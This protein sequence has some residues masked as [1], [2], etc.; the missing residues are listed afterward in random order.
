MFYDYHK[1][2][3]SLAVIAMQMIAKNANLQLVEFII[4]RRL[5]LL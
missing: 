4:T 2:L 5:V 3:E 1:T